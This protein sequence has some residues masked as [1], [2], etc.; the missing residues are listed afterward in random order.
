VIIG[1]SVVGTTPVVLQADHAYGASVDT[2]ID[3]DLI[4]G[5]VIA[6]LDG[7]GGGGGGQVIR[8][9]VREITGTGDRFFAGEEVTVLEG[10]DAD[11][12]HLPFAA[13][14]RLRAGSDVAA[15]I[16]AGPNGGLARLLGPTLAGYGGSAAVS[17]PDGALALTG[18]P[19]L[20]IRPGL[21]LCVLPPWTPPGGLEDEDLA[22]LPLDVAQALLSTPPA[23]PPVNAMAG[24]H[25]VSVDEET[26]SFAIVRTGGPLEALVGERLRVRANGR[27]VIVLVHH[28]QDFGDA[29]DEHLS[30]TRAAFKEIGPLYVET[31]E[32]S[33]EVLS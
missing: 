11:W 24:W 15:G 31:L 17:Y 1:S 20:A 5:S 28:E 8:P 23:S 29:D 10:A 14:P 25:S 22:R 16:H 13:P 12:V 33:V 19:V 21:V 6:R 2:A 3:T 9:V 26:G 7:H 32:V 27:S 18:G 30:L 4:V